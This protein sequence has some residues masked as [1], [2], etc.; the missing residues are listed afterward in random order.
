MELLVQPKSRGCFLPYPR[1]HYY[2]AGLLLLCI[3]AFHPNYFS[4]LS[5]SPWQYHAHAIAAVAWLLL[6]I[7]QSYSIHN[8]HRATHRQTG[9]LSILIT[10]LFL[11]SGVLVLGTMAKGQSPFIEMYSERLA[12]YDS[13][14]ILA[15]AWLMYLALR[16]RRNVQ[17]HA[18]SVLATSFL[19]VGPVLGR[20]MPG[21]VPG[22]TIRSIEDFPR[23]AYAI[24]LSNLIIVAIALFAYIRHPRGRKPMLW[25]GGVVVLQSILF[26]TLGRSDAWRET[27]NMLAASSP[28]MQALVGLLIGLI[29]V[30]LGW[31]RPKHS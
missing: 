31:T 2:L 24:H 21:F 26:E 20:L 30:Y 18:S 10:P 11:A 17:I 27:F 14:S 5:T 3:P 12:I 23:F 6:V 4:K 22:L 28:M 15:F 25:I 29:A 13:V 9:L 19:L 1:A 8:D 16:H 7:W